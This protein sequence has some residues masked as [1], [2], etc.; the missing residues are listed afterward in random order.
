LGFKHTLNSKKNVV[1]QLL[2]RCFQTNNPFEEQLSQAMKYSLDAGGKRIRPVLLLEATELCGGDEKN[3][4][5]HAIAIE[6]IHTYS[7]IHD[8]LPAMDDD[9]FR[10][11]KPTN[12]KVYGEALAILAG[13]GLLNSAFE[14]M[15][16]SSLL[17]GTQGALLATQ[18]I[19]KAAGISGMIGGQV[20]DMDSED[21]QVPFETLNYIHEHKTGALLTAPLVAGAQLAGA[22]DEEVNALKTYGYHIGLAFQITDDILDIEGSEE[23]LGKDIGSDQENNKTTYPS[24]FGLDKSKDLAKEHIDKAVNAVSVFGEKARFLNELAFFILT[25]D[26]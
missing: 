26:H 17:Q 11:G 23:K 14:K 12:H 7:L 18:T 13:D 4:Y 22:N 9:D 19:T 6:M 1:E 3:A 24:L 16:N 10:R 20:I 8:D 15:I 5:E 25:R 2:A 21:V